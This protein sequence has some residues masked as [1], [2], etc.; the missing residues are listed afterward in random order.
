MLT[1]LGADLLNRWIYVLIRVGE[2]FVVPYTPEGLK[3]VESAPDYPPDFIPFLKRFLNALHTGEWPAGSY[4]PGG[5]YRAL[6][7]K[8]VEPGAAPGAASGAASGETPPDF[9]SLRHFWLDELLVDDRGRWFLGKKTVMGKVRDLFL[10]NMS[11]D[12][13]LG[14]YRVR[15]WLE[16]GFD[17]RY[18]HH[19]APPLWVE[20]IIPHPQYCMVGLNDGLQEKLR[21]DTLFLDNRERLFCAVKAQKLPA[22]FQDAPRWALLKEARES[23]NGEWLVS[24]AGEEVTLHTGE[25]W[26][27]ADGL[28][29]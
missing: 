8:G 13:A 29:E 19:Q 5:W 21:A 18:L 27:Y 28:P 7:E 3:L 4:Y 6:A 10:A 26:P 17:T 22:Q 1:E 20:R 15:Y 12:Q 2:E 23:E 16:K 9:E 11:Y 24:I 14:R 25:E